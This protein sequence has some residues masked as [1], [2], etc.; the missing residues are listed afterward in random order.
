MQRDEP[1]A[2]TDF[3]VLAWLVVLLFTLFGHFSYRFSPFYSLR[4]CLLYEANEIRAATLRSIRYYVQT[5]RALRSLLELNLHH[6]IARSMDIL[7]DN[8]TERSQALRLIRHMLII[9]PAV[10]PLGLGRCLAAIAGD[11]SL[12]KDQLLRVV[13][14]TMAEL[15]T[16]NPVVGAH[17]GCIAVLTR[18]IINSATLTTSN[19]AP[20]GEICMGNLAI[21][22]ELNDGGGISNCLCTSA[23]LT[24][25]NL[26][27]SNVVIS[28]A[29]LS[30]LLHLYNWPDTRRLLQ[31]KGADLYYFISPFTDAYSFLH[32]SN[33]ARNHQL[34]AFQVDVQ[35]EGA[36]EDGQQ[37]QAN[38]DH[39]G[40]GE[41][42][43]GKGDRNRR[44]EKEAAQQQAHQQLHVN[45]EYRT[46]CYL[47]CK[48]ALLSI[49]RSWPG[50]FFM[51]RTLVSKR[52]SRS[53]LFPAAA[54]DG[55]DGSGNLWDYSEIYRQTGEQ[56][57]RSLLDSLRFFGI[58]EEVTP[59]RVT[60]MVSGIGR[61]M[62]RTSQRSSSYFTTTSFGS[63]NPLESLIAILHLPYPEVHRHLLELL[64]ELFGF[65]PPDWL[66][67]F[68]EAMRCVYF[69]HVNKR[70][71]ASKQGYHHHQHQ[72][73]TSF[74]GGGVST[75]SAAAGTNSTT[76][77][78]GSTSS[79]TPSTTAYPQLRSYYPEEWQLY[80][81]FVAGEAEY[82]LPSRC[83]SRLNYIT[84]YT[85]LLLQC[86]VEFGLLEALVSVILDS[87]E[88]AAVNLAT[89]LL[90]EL[91]HLT[92]KYLPASAYAHRCQ[93]LPSLVA[94]SISDCKSRRHRALTAINHLSEISEL[95]KRGPR[96]AS[97]YLQQQLLF[98]Q[99]PKPPAKVATLPVRKISTSSVKSVDDSVISLIKSTGVLKAKKEYKDWNWDV[100]VDILKHPGEGLRKLDDKDH[101]RLFIRRLVDFLKPSRRQFSLVSKNSSLM[102]S[103]LTGPAPSSF[104]S[105]TSSSA[106]TASASAASTSTSHHHHNH[107]HHHHNQ[108]SSG[109]TVPPQRSEPIYMENPRLL[110]IAAS[111]LVDFL[112]EADEARAAEYIEELLLDLDGS[113]K[114]IT[115]KAPASDEALLPSRLTST[116]AHHYFLL[117][118][119]F[120]H[121]PVGRAWLDRTH[122]Y[123]YLLDLI[124]LASSTSDLYIKLIV[125]SL[126]YGEANAM[127][128]TLLSK[129]L[130]ATPDS[131]RIYATRFLRVLLRARAAHFSGWAIDAL[132]GQLYDPCPA[133]SSLALDILDEACHGDELCLEKVISHRPTIFHL[134]D[135]G[136]TF[137]TRF[138]AHPI[139]LA[140]L[141]E[142][143]LLASELSRWHTVF[144]GRYVRLVEDSL[145]EC[146]SVHQRSEYGTFGRRA[147]KRSYPNVKHIS[148]TA[149]LPPHLYGQLVQTEEG[150]AVV[151]EQQ[152]VPEQVRLL[153]EHIE[154]LLRTGTEEEEEEVVE[155]QNDE[156]NNTGHGCQGHQAPVKPNEATVL[157]VKATLW[158]L[159][160]LCTSETGLAFV[161]DRPEPVLQWMAALSRHCPVLS[162]RGTTFYVL[163][164]VA[165]TRRGCQLLADFGWTAIQH[166]HDELFPI[167]QTEYDNFYYNGRPRFMS[168]DSEGKATSASLH[169]EKESS[170]AL[171]SPLL[172]NADGTVLTAPSTPFFH[173]DDVGGGGTGDP[174]IN[175]LSRPFSQS[176]SRSSSSSYLSMHAHQQQQQ[177]GNSAKQVVEKSAGGGGG[178]ATE[179]TGKKSQQH[180]QQ[181]T[182]TLSSSS[183]SASIYSHTSSVGNLVS[184]PSG[185]NAS[186][187]SAV[188][189]NRPR[190]SSDCVPTAVSSVGRL[191]QKP[192]GQ[193]SGILEN[194]P[195]GNS[196]TSLSKVDECPEDNSTTNSN[197]STTNG[198]SNTFNQSPLPPV[199]APRSR[200]ISAPCLNAHI[201]AVNS[202][203]VM[204]GETSNTT[205]SR[206]TRSDSNDSSRTANT[207]PSYHSSGSTSTG[208]G[209]RSTS[210][211]EYSTTTSSSSGS[212]ILEAV[213]LQPPPTSMAAMA[214]S[215]PLVKGD[216][217][218]S[219][220]P[221]SAAAATTLE[222][223]HT[224]AATTDQTVATVQRQGSKSLDGPSF[225]L[226]G[227]LSSSSS[228]RRTEPRQVPSRQ[229]S[230]MANAYNHYHHQQ[231]H[232]ADDPYP[233]PVDAHGY[234]Q[235]QAIQRR[236]VQSLS[237]NMFFSGLVGVAAAASVSPVQ[238]SAMEL[239]QMTGSSAFEQQ[240][241]PGGGG[242]VLLRRPHSGSVKSAGDAV[243]GEAM[244]EILITDSNNSSSAGGGGGGRQRK[245]SHGSLPSH[246][247]PVCGEVDHLVKRML[248]I[249]S[250][251]SIEQDNSGSYQTSQ[252]Q[253]QP[254]Q[255]LYYNRTN[256]R[257]SKG[258]SFNS[259]D[260]SS[261][262]TQLGGLDGLSLGGDSFASFGGGGR[263]ERT[264][265]MCLC[266]PDCLSLIFHIDEVC[267]SFLS[268][269]KFYNFVF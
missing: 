204:I 126:D 97:L 23:M 146:F 69:A 127:C 6:L 253:Q 44:R 154:E 147:E 22:G 107:H 74:E 160:H 213:P 142:S 102:P 92:G 218:V 31:P 65:R 201:S 113:F 45:F 191:S 221:D 257:V 87:T 265:F 174:T 156:N 180:Q 267:L 106:A 117:V 11:N 99:R 232:L 244:P 4:P 3:E 159:G 208:T 151:R 171:R 78:S 135:I 111:A 165:S 219:F 52:A 118:G 134:G 220:S 109:S 237:G 122:I 7:L 249:P 75:A 20:I 8:R 133:V 226:R 35:F 177:S 98:C 263:S 132:M 246:S 116:I 150:C 1:E 205:T 28:E 251:N 14:A 215:T 229:L 212:H 243:A 58:P 112:L 95:K 217:N 236:R 264:Q 163:C 223:A 200:K 224:T 209:S 184:H 76:S 181:R 67:D 238:P 115:S 114:N 254:S 207:A 66:E 196:K 259:V 189:Y 119:R 199:P 198:S 242:G 168:A 239:L 155:N 140:Y 93:S 16:I 73:F 169:D 12:E 164:L 139:G 234:A 10:F 176:S 100:V 193:D 59:T 63:K 47:A 89:I 250:S 170:S 121:S 19:S 56:N 13:W 86:L 227:A 175:P 103:D 25:L 108:S 190:S 240:S 26:S 79:S 125:S 48:S 9:E 40:G 37:Q 192:D 255:R 84:N 197:T 120:T 42:G 17:S 149:Y 162:L 261:N 2:Y 230:L 247:S 85:A 43:G 136:V 137:F 241:S 124:S 57:I 178:K 173:V 90:G 141:K 32:A 269:S 245:I 77:G 262:G 27:I 153:A 211:A 225:A 5:K 21:R 183:S 187:G 231:Q 152:I 222:G 214:T 46:I 182:F 206:E 158:A 91:L 203:V 72:S 50:M 143:N 18:C 80:E 33:A 210:F 83:G 129:V 172:L 68:D 167:N 256:S 30:A 96:P 36:A 188:S 60:Q 81:D 24:S 15:V 128:R 123:Q 131:S 194:H 228:C 82:V 148:T 41:N 216:R 51:C 195:N 145:N 202:S 29:V 61:A 49:L 235:L 39:G 54:D 53:A 258:G 71:K 62:D 38:G 94:A 166:S 185:V 64:F 144:N 248:R 186:S 104:T 268:L 266:L 138:A 70:V 161:L 130:T 157:R 88:A 34:N 252:Q 101:H 233:S 179:D 260:S 55:D 105:S 110:C